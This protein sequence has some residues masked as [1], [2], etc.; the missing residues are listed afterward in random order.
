MYQSFCNCKA[1]MKVWCEGNACRNTGNDFIS[2]PT[3]TSQMFPYTFPNQHWIDISKIGK[4]H[5]RVICL[6]ST[7]KSQRK[8]QISL[9]S[10]RPHYWFQMC[11][12]AKGNVLCD[13]NL[14]SNSLATL[15]EI[16]NKGRRG[17]Q[18]DY[19]TIHT[20]KISYTRTFRTLTS[21]TLTFCTPRHFVHP[22]KWSTT[23]SYTQ[24]SRTPFRL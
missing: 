18:I 22:D 5:L 9:D 17:S 14:N 23:I 8:V 21:G 24:T 12:F 2:I 15:A 6:S 1:A 16:L 4:T 3:M 10:R 19:M 13:K 20:P 11:F 7:E